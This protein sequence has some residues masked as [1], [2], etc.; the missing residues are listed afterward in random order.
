MGDDYKI[1]PSSIMLL[2]TSAFVEGYDRGTKWV[3]FLIEDDDL[4]K[5]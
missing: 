3:C 2:K 4:L 1:K 5:I